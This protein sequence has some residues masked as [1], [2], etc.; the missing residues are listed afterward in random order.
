MAPGPNTSQPHPEHPVYPYLLRGVEVT[1]SNQVWSYRYHVR[2]PGTMA[3]P[4]WWPSSTGA[5]A[6]CWPGGFPTRMEAGFCVEAVWKRRSVLHGRPEI[7]NTDQGSTVHRARL[8]R[9]RSCAQGI[10]HQHGWTRAGI[11]QHYS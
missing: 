5:R 7:F 3:L 4:T 8:S 10:A 9:G 1:R 11:G 6:G 2:A